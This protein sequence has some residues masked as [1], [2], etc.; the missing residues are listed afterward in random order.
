MGIVQKE[1]IKLTAVIYIGAALGYLNKVLLFTHFLSTTQVGL[2]GLLGNVS[3]LYAQF[4]TLGIPSISNRFFP[5]FNNKEK[6]HNGFFFWGNVFVFVGFLISTALFVLFKPLI[7]SQYIDNSPML[8]DYYYYLI[9][10]ALASIYF[11]FFESYLRSLLKTVVPTILN[12][13]FSKIVITICI[14]MYAL[15]WIDFHQFVIIYVL[16]N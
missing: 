10:L 9:P 1:G 4:A 16:C 15:K 5:F 7:I 8:I 11:Q 2:I 13:V 6:R 3:V 12:E 14:S